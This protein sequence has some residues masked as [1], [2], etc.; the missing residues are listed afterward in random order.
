MSASKEHKATNDTEEKAKTKPLLDRPIRLAKAGKGNFKRSRSRLIEALWMIVEFFLV[1]NPLQVSS[2]VRASALRFFGARIGRN[3]IM[4]QLRVKFPWNL[5]VG[6]D[7]WFG[8]GVWIHNQGLVTIEENTALAHEVFITTGSHNIY[9]SMDLIVKPVIIRRGAWL[10]TRCMIL[11]GVDVGE[12][13]V[14][15]PN[16][17]VNRSVPPNGIYAGNPAQFIRQRWQE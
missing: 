10:A 1:S 3:V 4:R 14:V 8:E 16:S 9:E 13:A 5:E 6:N 17:V 15:T 12:N 7:C 11:Q 2:R